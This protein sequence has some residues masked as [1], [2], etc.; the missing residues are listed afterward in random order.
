MKLRPHHL[1]C[2]Q[3]FSGSGYSDT[4]VENM[5][6][7]V[8]L[9]RSDANVTI[10]IVF[11]TDDICEECPKKLGDDLCSSN[12]KVTFFDQKVVDYFGVEERQYQYKNIIS[13]IN[14]QMTSAI[15]DDIC[16]TCEWYPTS[17]CKSNI[18]GE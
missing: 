6:A 5:T 1:L 18:L 8:N 7:I 13:K 16:G 2:T 9:L 17:A 11:S 4:F 10:Q 15:M 14:E 12:E 3:G